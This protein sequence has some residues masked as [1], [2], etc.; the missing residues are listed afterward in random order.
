VLVPEGAIC[1]LT[2]LS[3]I[4]GLASDALAQFEVVC[5]ALLHDVEH[6]DVPNAQLAKEKPEIAKD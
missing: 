1:H 5:S 6:D 4:N 3:S 2:S